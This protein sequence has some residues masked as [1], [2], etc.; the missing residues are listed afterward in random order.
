MGRDIVMI[1]AMEAVVDW[2]KHAFICKFN[3]ISWPTYHSFSQVTPLL[4]Y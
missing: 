4:P 2:I 1:G 3:G